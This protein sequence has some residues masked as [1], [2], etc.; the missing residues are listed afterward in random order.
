MHVRRGHEVREVMRRL[1]L[2]LLLLWHLH[3][4]RVLLWH[5]VRVRRQ[6]RD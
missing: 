4:V 1:A 5:L 3:L 2:L 6:G